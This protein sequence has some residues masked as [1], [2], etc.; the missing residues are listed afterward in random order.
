MQ[1]QS[2]LYRLAG[3]LLLGLVL[4]TP[5]AAQTYSP[6][7]YPGAVNGNSFATDISDCAQIVGEY[8]YGASFGNQRYGYVYSNG[9]FAPVIYPGSL[10]TRAVAANCNGDI[11]GDYIQK[12][13]SGNA[14]GQERGY[15][16]HN[17]V[18]TT[19]QYPNSDGT[20]AA[21]INSGGDIV[22]WYWDKTGQHG[23][24][25]QSGVYSS[26]DFPGNAQFTQAWKINDAGEIDGRYIGTSDGNYHIFVWS[27]GVYTAVADVPGSKE[28]AT[29]EDG[30]LNNLGDI[31]G[32]Y[33]SSKPCSL[34][35]VLTIHG[36]LLSNGV[37]TTF[38]YPGS[39][40]TIAFGLN[41]SE[42][43]VGAY[44][45]PTGVI[46]GYLRTP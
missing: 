28:T 15:L 21:G 44:V 31:A 3:S 33:C 40:W 19:L 39:L 38:D 26:I 32:N 27:N 14:N 9:T 7:D 36:F 5:A 42:I 8:Q 41:S 1:S 17:G 34:N 11:V 6:I 37:Y 46:H 12:A 29:I 4:S 22:G 16:L 13:T 35:G 43:I 23:F 25:L 18:Y 30:G 45:D 10:W 24:L 20:I 2:K